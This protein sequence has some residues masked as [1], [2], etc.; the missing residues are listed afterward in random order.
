MLS[1]DLDALSYPE[2]IP[3]LLRLLRE[4]AD[5]AAVLTELTTGGPTARYLAVVAAA[6]T[7]HRPIVVQALADQDPAVRAEAARQALRRGWTTGGEL[8]GDAP[9]VLRHLILRLL[10]RRPG[11]GDAV[12]DLVRERYGDR[13]AAVVLP[14]CSAPVVVRL[15]PD[16]ARSVV[17]WK[18]LARRHSAAVLD[19]ADA[20]LSGTETPDWAPVV[21][22][23]RACVDRRPERVLDLLERHVRDSLPDVGLAPI[24]A[25]FPARVVALVTG[26]VT[27]Q[28][29]YQHLPVE[30]LR[31]LL[32]LGV[33]DLVAVDEIAPD[34][35]E[36]LPADRRVEVYTASRPELPYQGRV[37]SLP[38][39]ARVREVRR[40]LALPQ[41][42]AD[43][44]QTRSWSRL[45]PAAESLPILDEEARDHRPYQRES[46]YAEMVGV[47]A[48]EPT[49]LTQVLE[50]L[51]RMRNEREA[52]RRP[53]LRALRNLIPHLTGAVVP[54]LTAITDAAIESRDLSPRTEEAL[55]E[56]AWAALAG[57]PVASTGDGDGPARWALGMIAR[58]PIPWYIETPLRPGQER[59]VTAALLKRITADPGEL[60]KLV[61][62]LEKRA[63]QVPEL[64]DLLRRAAAPSSPADV[65]DKAV[66]GWLDDPRTRPERVADLL[67]EDPAVVRLAPVWREVTGWTT[68]LLDSLLPDPAG[69][70]NVAPGEPAV[71]AWSSVVAAGP[72]VHVRRWSVRQQRSY[73]AALAAVAADTDVEQRAR[74][75]AVRSLA[76]VPVAGRELLAGFLDAPEPPIAEA[77]LS[78]LP[79]TDRPDEAL[80]ILLGYAGGDR[81]GAALPA[82]DRAAR[83]VSPSALITLLRGVLL[84]PPSEVRVSSRKAAARILARYGPPE[85]TDLLAE[86][87]HTP[88]VHSDVRA[89]IVAA[90]RGQASSPAA[91]DILTEAAASA[92]HAVVAALLGAVPQ[93]LPEPDRN[94]FAALVAT[95]CAA[96]DLR[97]ARDA[98]RRLPEWIPWAPDAVALIADALVHPGHVTPGATRP[99]PDLDALVGVLLEHSPPADS[100]RGTLA[101]VFARLIADDHA[102]TRVGTPDRDRPARRILTRIVG[103]ASRWARADRPTDSRAAHL[104]AARAAARMLAA[105]PGLLAD[106][107]ALLLALAESRLVPLAEVADL[108]AARPALAV[109]LA[110]QLADRRPQADPAADLAGTAAALGDRGDLAGGLFAVAL[111]AAAGGAS[112]WKAPWP[113]ALNRLR[114]HPDPDVADAAYRRMMYR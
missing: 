57:R 60:L 25:R 19:W 66:D 99:D 75:V 82:A 8:L 62:L 67:R 97:I 61:D 15:L 20:V 5:P 70:S 28:T 59:L 78:A 53:A 114:A 54:L 51:L 83:F 24:A 102:D 76:R 4:Q 10:R 40:I 11:S 69:S 26:R 64:Q 86:V 81:A 12:I 16:L 101:S 71:V 79:W 72:P 31:H 1:D 27:W 84:A 56:L 106:G 7:G 77:A 103:S 91:W 55:V 94:R 23:V 90:L 80:P 32:G 100:D 63:R 13:E 113:E 112:R 48:G 68:T 110:G 35:F 21:D 33:D 14:A 58:L 37:E 17:S 18:V 74:I 92:E 111:V 105:D 9:P 36:M 49:A 93:D 88:D 47:A 85:S 50:R 41:I 3:A 87:W 52:V 34:F 29:S 45:L 96:S 104:P 38:S 6:A 108:V 30:V 39:A 2:R 46:A 65:R 89:A 98:L 43:E 95:A 109:R 73:A 22:A 107:A 44:T 42:A